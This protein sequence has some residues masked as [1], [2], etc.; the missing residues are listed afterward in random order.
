[1]ERVNPLA[2]GAEV[3][4]GDVLRLRIDEP[5]RIEPGS[6][7]A[8]RHRD[9]R[10]T[11][12]RLAPIAG[13][14]DRASIALSGLDLTPGRWDAYLLGPDEQ[15]RGSRI[16]CTDPGHGIDG[17]LRYARRRRG[18]ALRAYRTVRDGHLAVHAIESPPHAEIERV[19]LDGSDI[20]ITGVL[21]Y[22]DASGE[23]EA[24]VIAVSQLDAARV[25]GVDCA[26]AEGR[27]TAR[28]ALASLARGGDRD[29][30]DLWLARGAELLR[31]A[32]K[33]DGIETKAKRIRYPERIVAGEGGRISARPAWTPD[34]DGLSIAVQP[35]GTA[36]ER[37]AA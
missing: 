11:D 12:F 26:V 35:L 3:D 32:A 27:F 15:G 21:A 30:W 16:R 4:D 10:D 29:D 25:S 5:K 6:R 14:A 33:L 7:L 13:D 9:N 20:V 2:V 34:G 31:L 17:L 36:G 37:S 8:L 19:D 22:A 18:L 24:A 28:L 1:M 23:T